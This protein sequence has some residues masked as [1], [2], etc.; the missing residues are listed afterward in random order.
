MGNSFWRLQRFLL[1]LCLCLGLGG[2]VRSALAAS[3][4][5][6]AEASAEPVA[7]IQ[8][9]SDALNKIRHALDDADAPETLQALLDQAQLSKRSA[10]SAV[11]ALE[12]LLA[13]VEARVQQLGPVDD[14]GADGGVEG[15]DLGRQRKLLDQ[16]RGTIDSALK[17]GKLLSVEAAQMAGAIEKMRTQQFNEEISRKVSSPLSLELWRQFADHVPVDLQRVGALARQ[18]RQALQ[19]A[20][21]EQGVRSVGAPQ[22]LQQPPGY[23]D[24][25]EGEIA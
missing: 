14:A 4:G 15:G 18:G 23:H 17:R 24:A 5:I 21:A 25:A 3:A 10:D 8:A 7:R 1:A 13:Q 16:E 2:M 6:T 20:V 11:L 22:F 9:A 12:P 19:Q